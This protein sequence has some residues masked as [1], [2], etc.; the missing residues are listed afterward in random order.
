MKNEESRGDAPSAGGETGNEL[1]DEG[2][3]RAIIGAFYSVYNRFR[4]GL[5][6]RIYV[7]ALQIDLEELGFEVEC[8][9]TIQVSYKGHAIGRYRIDL[10]VNRRVVVEV[11][12]SAELCPFDLKQA[13]TYVRLSGLSMG[14]LLHFGAEAKF[15]KFFSDAGT[16]S[17]ASV[18]NFPM[19]RIRQIYCDLHDGCH[20]EERYAAKTLPTRK[21]LGNDTKDTPLS[22]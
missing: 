8:E 7:R 22:T 16:R 15:Y 5:P 18:R 12:S 21:G 14:V 11:K 13:R 2:I 3:T 4:P 20:A 6:E 1:N 10:L 19:G 9:V 17:G